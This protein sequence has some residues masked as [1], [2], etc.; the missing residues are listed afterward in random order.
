MCPAT[1]KWLKSLNFEATNWGTPDFSASNF[2]KFYLSLIF[3][4]PENLM[5]LTWVVK[6]LN[7]GGPN[8]GRSPSF[9]IHKSCQMLSYLYNFMCLTW[10]VKKFW[11]LAALFEGN[12]PFWNL[13]IWSNFI[14]TLYLLTI[15]ISCVQLKRLKTLIFG[16]PIWEKPPFWNPEFLLSFVY[17]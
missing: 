13:Q 11:I 3:A 16:G 2:V 6:S 10:M 9:G 5:H 8:G 14:S 4:Y 7:F 1:V 15:K 12:L 17:F